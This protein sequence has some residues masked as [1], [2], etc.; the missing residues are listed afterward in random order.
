[1][2]RLAESG[3]GGWSVVCGV[4]AGALNSLLVAQ[5]LLEEMVRLW[6][7]QAHRGLPAFRS[8]LD[9][10]AIAA[11]AVAPGILAYADLQALDG[12]FDNRELAEIVD[13]FT[14]GLADRLTALR[15]QLRLGV[16]CL[17]TGEYLAADPI[18]DVEPRQVTDLV[19]ASTAIP[20]AFDPVELTVVHEGLA[21]SGRPC[22][23]AD[24]GTRNITPLADAIHTANEAGLELEGLD[25]VMCSPFETTGTNH[26][27]HGLLDIGLRAEDILVNEIYRNDVELFRRANLLASFRH[28]MEDAQGDPATAH[29]ATEALSLMESHQIPIARYRPLDLRI[30]RPTLN[31]WRAFTNRREADLVG[32]FPDTLERNGETVRLIIGYGRWLAEHGEFHLTVPADI[33]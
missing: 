14:A 17:Q 21:C 29:L 12:L 2:H 27:F 13:P 16:V 28:L 19:L 33:T 8:R 31:S 30:I 24:G 32:E 23:F 10:A 11:H 20:L 18:S 9:A 1:M 5:D 3:Q 15:R 4:S 22:Q 6:E 26:E 25:V 7:D